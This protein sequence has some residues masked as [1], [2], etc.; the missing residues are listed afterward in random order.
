MAF[1]RYTGRHHVQPSRRHR[2][3]AAAVALSGAAGVAALL[4]SGTAAS[5][6]SS[7]NWD[8]IAQC[9]SSGNWHINTGN[10][11]YGGLQFAQS[12]WQ[13]YGGTKYAARADLATR[14][15]QIAVA[16]KVLAGQGI[17]AW[18][19]CGARAGASTP[20]PTSTTSKPA[21]TTSKPAGT[22]TKPTGGASHRGGSTGG[23]S[24]PAAGKGGYTVRPGDTLSAIAAKH[25][26]QGGWHAL[27]EKNKRVV[28]AD[29]NLILP[30]QRLSL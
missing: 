26:V 19:V 21:S 5:A 29:P 18:P 1:S 17:G 27:Y 2:R 24:H 22:A 8:A 11:Y 9:E 25:H 16:E 4:G 10:G 6:A 13:A 12:T 15:Q 28:G 7:V 20:S 3:M 23:G 14:E 30:G